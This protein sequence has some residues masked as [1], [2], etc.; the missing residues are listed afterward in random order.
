MWPHLLLAVGKHPL[1]IL[2]D[3]ARALVHL[4]AQQPVLLHGD[5]AAP[6][7]GVAVSTE[8]S[9]RLAHREALPIYAPHQ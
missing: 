9:N 8:G 6:S 1:T 4:H 2:R 7:K 5:V 3:V